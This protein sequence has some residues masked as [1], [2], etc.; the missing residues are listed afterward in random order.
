MTTEQIKEQIQD[1]V[2]AYHEKHYYAI[3]PSG[4]PQLKDWHLEAIVE[5]L[6]P[7]FDELEKLKTENKKLKK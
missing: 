5:S 3:F 1:A 6:K 2:K 7:F 4:G